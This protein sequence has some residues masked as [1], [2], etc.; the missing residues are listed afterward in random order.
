[1]IQQSLIPTICPYCGAGCA[2]YV[3][4]EDGRAVGLE[5]VNDHPVSQGSLCPKGNAAL[6]ILDHPERLTKP[7]VRAETLAA[8]RNART[9]GTLSLSGAK[10]RRNSEERRTLWRSS[11]TRR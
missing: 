11:G 8:W 10:D 2:F 5:Y 6:E 3:I 1:M 7:L 4:V 9:G